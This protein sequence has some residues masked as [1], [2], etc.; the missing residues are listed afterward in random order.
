MS[1]SMENTHTIGN[2]RDAT[3]SD[4]I[5]ECSIQ[6]DRISFLR[7]TLREQEGDSERVRQLAEAI[8]SAQGTMR[9]LNTAYR[10]QYP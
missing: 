7:N 6:L 5:F 10:G 1:E 2:I 3:L 8:T 4:L 9:H